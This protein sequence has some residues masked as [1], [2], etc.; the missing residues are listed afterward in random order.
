MS[1]HSELIISRI[2]EDEIDATATLLANSMS[3]NPNHLAIFKSVEPG[4]IDMQRKMFLRGLSNVNNTTIVAR[5]N[6]R[7][8][9]TMTYKTSKTCQLPVAEL[10]KSMPDLIAAYGSYA[11]SILRWRMNWATHDF[12]GPHI[13]LGPLAVETSLQGTG[14]GKSLLT[15]FC[16][17]L[18]TTGQAA[19]LETD[20]EQ[21][22]PL[23]EKFGFK[24]IETDLLFGNK[25]WFMLRGV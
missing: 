4:I 10:K 13:H 25:N 23:Y 20:R 2:K 19:Y 8:V 16:S 5:L 18:D 1:S 17:Y 7:I 22:I 24:V 3:T 6:D 15:H 11:S 14:I 21:N 9:G 12:S